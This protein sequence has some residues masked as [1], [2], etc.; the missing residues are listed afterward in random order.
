MK[1]THL[2][3]R[4]LW[5]LALWA[6][7]P[8]AWADNTYPSKPVRI[9]IP[10]PAGGP[11][12]LMARL[13]AERLQQRRKQPFV[14]DNKA[15]AGGN[16]GADAVS[17]APADGHTLLLSAAG[18]LSVNSLLY[19]KL[20]YDPAAF[21]PIA[22]VSKSYSAL[23]VNPALKI[24]TVEDLIAY[25]KAHPGTLNYGSSGPGS[26]PQ[27]AAELFKGLAGV[28]IAHVPYRGSA[29]A[30]TDVI[31]GN[32]QMMFVE[33]SLARPQ[34]RAGKVRLL[35]I[36][37]ERRRGSLPDVPAVS[38]TLPGF[39]SVTW[40]GLAAPPQTPPGIAATLSRAV[41]DVLAQPDMAAR[42]A[43]VDGEPGGGTPEDVTRFI[44]QERARWSQVITA[45]RITAE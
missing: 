35:A 5:P 4:E 30:L 40:F 36:G 7:A 9:V 38:E 27:L 31:A 24:R 12:D 39:V 23:V 13:L 44:A 43:E 1:A 29:P 33:L 3:R 26:T 20:P 28:D 10:Y 37:S 42:F 15:G 14:I 25:A 21:V 11:P 22:I 45:N 6:V 34:I 19:N 16:I 41:A 17:R 18:P 2:K 32:V 8:A